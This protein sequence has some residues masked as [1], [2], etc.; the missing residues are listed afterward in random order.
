[1]RYY[2]HTARCPVC[3]EILDEITSPHKTLDGMATAMLLNEPRQEHGV[4]SAG[5]TEHP[6]WIKGWEIDDAVEEVQP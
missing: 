3:G 2:K 5:C 6:D 4:K 1:M